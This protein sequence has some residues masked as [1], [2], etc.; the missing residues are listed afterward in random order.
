MYEAFYRLTCKPFQLNPDPS[1]YFGSTPHRKAMAHLQYGLHQNEGFVVVTGEVGAG[2]T[3]LVR[4]LLEALDGQEVVAATLVSTQLG[5]DELLRT[6]AAAFGIPAQNAGKSELLLAIETFLTS[7]AHQGKRCLLVVDE[8]QNLTPQA[9]EELRMLTNFQIEQHALL[10]SFLIGQAEF[11]NVLQS[12]AMRQLRQRV[13]AAC[14]IGSLDAVETRAYI[15]HRLACA[16]LKDGLEIQS[17]AYLKIFESSGGIP[18]RINSLCDRLLL[19]GYLAEKRSFAA[20][21]VAGVAAEFDYELLG[22]EAAAAAPRPLQEPTGTG[23]S[24][25][26]TLDDLA[27]RLSRLEHGLQRIES[28]TAENAVLFGHMI[29][30][31]AARR[32]KPR[33]RE[34][35]EADKFDP[36]MTP[37]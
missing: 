18:R 12:P 14:H 26:A 1:F 25:V 20:L 4:G 24:V 34:R 28:T 13:I 21:D 6:V 16:G 30:Q 10:Q 9:L 19:S 11:R 7:V 3:T 23:D 29:E 33:T 36:P 5:A 27:A 8:V 2:K 37:E 17:D 22:P 15:E 31:L 35:R 32:R